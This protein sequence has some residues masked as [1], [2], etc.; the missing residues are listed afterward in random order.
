M[1][2]S[3]LT[4]EYLLSPDGKDPTG[5]LQEREAH[6]VKVIDAI[7]AVAGTREYSSLKTLIFDGRLEETRKAIFY[8]ARK[9]KPDIQLLAKLNGKYEE[10]RKYADLNEL[11]K[12]FQTELTHLKIKLHGTS[13]KS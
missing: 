1:N 2:N 13:D 12:V 10:V 7:K 11:A 5:Q 9:D 8:E 3:R 6:L 4:S